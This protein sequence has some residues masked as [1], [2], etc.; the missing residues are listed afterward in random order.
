MQTQAYCRHLD[1]MGHRFASFEALIRAVD[2]QQLEAL[3]T[4]TELYWYFLF[5]ELS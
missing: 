4:K 2:R 5:F 1:F 3:Q